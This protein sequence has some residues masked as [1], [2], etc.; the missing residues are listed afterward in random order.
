MYTVVDIPPLAHIPGFP[1]LWALS[2]T[3]NLCIVVQLALANDTQA[4]VIC[5]TVGEAF[6]S[7]YIILHNLSSSL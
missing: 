2:A 6:E 4:E 7:Q 5:V 3:L 1:L